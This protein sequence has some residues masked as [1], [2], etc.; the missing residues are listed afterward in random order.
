MVQDSHRGSAL[1]TSRLRLHLTSRK[2]KR[3]GQS[4]RPT[5]RGQRLCPRRGVHVPFGPGV[6]DPLGDQSRADLR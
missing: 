6:Y 1:S 4:R 3:L 2:H 5:V